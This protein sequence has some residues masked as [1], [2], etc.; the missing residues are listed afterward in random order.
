LNEAWL[1]WHSPTSEPQVLRAFS[2]S[3]EC[4]IGVDFNSDL[5][6]T[7]FGQE[8]IEPEHTGDTSP[9]EASER[10]GQWNRNQS[11]KGIQPSSAL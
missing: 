9:Q 1:H 4:S 7:L 6:G 11:T 5:I 3:V 2:T 10:R 8:P